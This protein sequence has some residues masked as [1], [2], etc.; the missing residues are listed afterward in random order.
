MKQINNAGFEPLT[1]SD[2]GVL[3][4]SIIVYV[5][6]FFA[7]RA[8]TGPKPIQAVQVLIGLLALYIFFVTGSVISAGFSVLNTLFFFILLTMVG[9]WRSKSFLFEDCRSI[10]ISIAFVTPLLWLALVKNNPLWDDYSHWLPSAQ[11]LFNYGHLPTLQEPV[12]NNAHPSYPYARALIHTFVNLGMD[13]FIMNVQGVF[14][15]L[16]A[17][18]LLL[19]AKPLLQFQ[20]KTDDNNSTIIISVMGILSFLLI[21][22]KITLNT[23]LIISSYADPL[24]S[25]CI[26]HLFLFLFTSRYNKKSFSSGKFNWLVSSLFLIP[27]IIKDAGI[28]YS[29]IIFI[30]YWLTFDFPRFFRKNVDLKLESKIFII[31][32]LHLMPLL[33]F[34]F[35][36]LFYIDTNGIKKSFA[37]LSINETKMEL[38]P[39]ILRAAELQILGRPYILLAI[40]LMLLILLFSKPSIWQ[41]TTSPLSIFTF[42]FI[43]T[44]GMILFHL[45]AYLFTF[46]PYE[47]ARA[48]SFSRYIAP[49]G[50]IAWA[51]LFI[52]FITSD[53]SSKRNTIIA[54]GSFFSLIFFSGVI[55]NSE[56]IN[57]AGNVNPNLKYVAE[58]IINK[59]PKGEPLLIFD[60]GTNGIDATIIRFYT[61]SYMPIGYVNSISLNGPLNGEILKKWMKDY[62]YIYIHSGSNQQKSLIKEYI[63]SSGKKMYQ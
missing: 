30:S 11:F 29:L 5:G 21:I 26:A 56:K 51:S 10:A 23:R 36:W 50:L 53:L 52:Y 2:F 13:T 12:I 34:K 54:S 14:N 49:A 18:S 48:A 59:Y 28:Y 44:T 55:L 4:L 3:F 43:T 41:K 6:L 9:V 57:V 46:V 33:L 62:E 15:I 38:I 42:A 22:W 63:T 47:A 7:G 8:F 25:I 60:L 61:N 37:K 45:L 27:I 35:I 58:K 40:F 20:H 24:Y 19:W 31:Q 16:F 39:Q 1:Y 32:V 17:S